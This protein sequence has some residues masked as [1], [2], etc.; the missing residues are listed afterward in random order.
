MSVRSRLRLLSLLA[1]ACLLLLS[2]GPLAA[3]PDRAPLRN[4]GSITVFA[5]AS[6]TEAFT[7]I[8]N[9]FDQANNVSVHFSF[10]GSDTL[11][12]QIVQG[13][14]AD[15]FASANQTQ[16]NVV[17]GKGLIVGT[18]TVFVRNRLVLI[19]PK[20]NPAHI[21][22][23]ADLGNPGVNLVL[24]AP[25]VPVGK[26]ARAA[27]AVMATDAAFGP[28]FLKRIEANVKSNETDVKAVAAKVS[29][30]EADAGI[31]YV[32]DVTPQVAAKVQEIPIP[33]PFNQV[34]VYPI[35]VTKN[36]QNA[37]LAQK[38][39]DY[40]LSPAGKAVLAQR[41][42]ITSSPAGGYAASF[43]VSG[44]VS[45]P[46]TFSVSG[47]QKLPATTQTI[48]IRTESSKAGA[49][50]SYTGPTLYT[51]LQQAGLVPNNASFKNDL[52]RQFVTIVGSDNYQVTVAMAEILPTFGNQQVLLAYKKDNRALGSDEGAVRLIVPGDRLAGRDVNNVT[53]II[54][55][56][57]VGTP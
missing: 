56:T 4:N 8:G 34:A 30:G 21:T 35:A 25:A 2:A 39:V 55:G 28:D 13:A 54:V 50:V 17:A 5:A 57:P 38:F 9:A 27:F 19:V 43:T 15:V 26:Y 52:L 22:N 42:F 3:A 33:A 11:A 40:V 46:A 1:P 7:T 20:N 18:P 10:G 41:R 31:V 37:T 14:P 51:V 45:G 6:L 53:Q 48:T 36:A 24:A 12:T 49:P 32:T 23:L 47:L 44:L 16:M 29:L